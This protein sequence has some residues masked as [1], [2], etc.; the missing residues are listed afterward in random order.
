MQGVHDGGF[1]TAFATL[2]R[3]L[4][5]M[6]EG[7]VDLRELYNTAEPGG[8]FSTTVAAALEQNGVPTSMLKGLT[9]ST[10]QRR[11]TPPPSHG[12]KASN[13][14]AAGRTITPT[15]SGPSLTG[16]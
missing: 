4:V 7:R 12:A 9:H 8:N 10:S 13:G 14:V 5:L 11:P 3:N 1:A 2:D 6:A 16:P 15:A